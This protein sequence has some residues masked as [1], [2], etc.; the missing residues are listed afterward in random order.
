MQKI[1]AFVRLKIV[2]NLENTREFAS[3]ECKGQGCNAALNFAV[4]DCRFRT[5]N[6]FNGH[7]ILCYFVVKPLIFDWGLAITQC[8][9]KKK[10]IAKAVVFFSYIRLTASY[11]ASQ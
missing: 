8:Y 2:K 4:L 9:R 3:Q 7:I 5:I 10:T 11:I 1:F 6:V